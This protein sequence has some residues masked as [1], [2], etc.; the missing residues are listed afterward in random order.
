MVGGFVLCLFPPETYAPPMEPLILAR[1][2]KGLGHA[3][4]CLFVC[5]WG[6]AACYQPLFLARFYTGLGHAAP[7][8]FV[9]N[10]WLAAC[11]K[12]LF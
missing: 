2:Y 10:W 1:F 11:Y 6:L 7:C 12:P 3:G 9:C 8:L 4:P 5:N